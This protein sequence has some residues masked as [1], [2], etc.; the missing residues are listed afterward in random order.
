MT[1]KD[2]AEMTQ[3]LAWFTDTT[4]RDAWENHSDQS[5]KSLFTFDQILEYLKEHGGVEEIFKL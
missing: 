3:E 4:V 5:I 1:L 2:A